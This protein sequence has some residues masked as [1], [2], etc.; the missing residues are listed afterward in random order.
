[1]FWFVFGCASILCVFM[2]CCFGVINDGLLLLSLFR[3][4]FL[5]IFS[6]LLSSYLSV[7]PQVWHV[8]LCFCL[9]S[10]YGQ[11]S[12]SWRLQSVVLHGVCAL[13]CHS[14]EESR[15]KTAER[16][17]CIVQASAF[18]VTAFW[19]AEKSI[20]TRILGQ[21]PITFKAYRVHPISGPDQ[22]LG[23]MHDFCVTLLMYAVAVR[24]P[25]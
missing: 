5:Y 3:I 22:V 2:F 7:Q 20:S 13:K 12:S 23:S 15:Q 8:M 18:A 11:T 25:K 4:A 6:N 16:F 1:M 14:K 9:S 19:L 21:D 17:I 24:F 10:L